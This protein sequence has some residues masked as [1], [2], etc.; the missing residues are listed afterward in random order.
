MIIM[1]AVILAAPDVGIHIQVMFKELL[2]IL[3]EF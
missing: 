3:S 1:I 2:F